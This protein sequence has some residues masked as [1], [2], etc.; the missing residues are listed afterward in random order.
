M[1]ARWGTLTPAPTRFLTPAEMSFSHVPIWGFS[2]GEVGVVIYIHTCYTCNTKPMLQK[3]AFQKATH[4]NT[5]S[6][7]C[8]A[9]W[10]VHRPMFHVPSTL[11]QAG[12]KNG[13]E[14]GLFGSYGIAGI[15]EP[16]R[17]SHA[18]CSTHIVTTRCLAL[19]KQVQFTVVHHQ[20]VQR[21]S[22]GCS[23]FTA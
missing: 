8:Q 20:P 17:L 19:A 22:M 11:S 3:P 4:A 1:W 14:H 18:R 12:A 16:K 2:E 7:H 10:L 13:G 15:A 9:F 23:V 6:H 21:G 5:N